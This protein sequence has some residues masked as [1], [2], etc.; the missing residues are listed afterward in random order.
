MK[1]HK[2]GRE[3]AR[4]GE[5]EEEERG[6]GDAMRKTR[7]HQVRGGQKVTGRKL[8]CVRRNKLCS[9]SSLCCKMCLPA[10]RCWAGTVGFWVES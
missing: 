3:E 9:C 5:E 6:H 7:V 2:A 8:E 10:V 4:V 1:S